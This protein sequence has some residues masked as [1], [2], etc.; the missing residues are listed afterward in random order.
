MCCQRF[1]KIASFD[2]VVCGGRVE[3]VLNGC[4]CAQS[5]VEALR[6]PSLMKDRGTVPE[7]HLK[8]AS[9]AEG[10]GDALEEQQRKMIRKAMKLQSWPEPDPCYVDDPG[11]LDSY[12]VGMG[13]F[14]ES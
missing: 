7:R 9:Q 6:G 2:N 8:K 12:L 10:A 5:E 4:H 14:W 13:Y 11:S 3:Q 1:V